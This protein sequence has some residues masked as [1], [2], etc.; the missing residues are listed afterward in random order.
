MAL[1]LPNENAEWLSALLGVI[2]VFNTRGITAHAKLAYNG[3]GPHAT[4]INLVD[5]VLAEHRGDPFMP[6]VLWLDDDNMVTPEIIRRWISFLDAHPEADIVVGWCWV[7]WGV[8]WHPSVGGFNEDESNVWMKLA[9]VYEGGPAIRHVPNLSS[10]FPCVM[11]RREVLERLGATAFWLIPSDKHRYGAIPEDLAF[12]WRA[13]QAKLRCY[14][15][16]MA[17]VGHLKKGLQE[18]TIL[19]DNADPKL[20]EMIDRVNGKPVQAPTEYHV[21]L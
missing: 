11:M 17:R 2:N 5:M 1:C 8:E 12:F 13:K 20:R 14:L 21:N 7:N 15:D 16:P 3:T 9:D 10:G 6:Y 18:P 4:R 19:Y